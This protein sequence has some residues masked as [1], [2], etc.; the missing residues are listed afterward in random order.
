MRRCE[1]VSSTI[2]TAAQFVADSAGDKFRAIDY[3][4][5][6]PRATEHLEWDRYLRSRWIEISAEW[7]TFRDAGGRLPNIEWLVGQWQGNSGTWQGGVLVSRGRPTTLLSRHF[8]VTIEALGRV[9]GLRLALWS[10]HLPGALIPEHQGPNP[11]VLRFHLG[12]DCPAD[13]ALELESRVLPYRNGETILFDDTAPHAA[14]NRSDRERVTLF[15]ELLRP[16]PTPWHQL[17]QFSQDLLS[18]TARSRAIQR[19][20]A[21]HVALNPHLATRA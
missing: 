15:C 14:W 9:P 3:N 2:K 10:V 6:N 7:H 16:L 20:D 1:S 13:A 12:V 11:G 8:P 17:N 18:L 4:E 19:S 21:W 5:S